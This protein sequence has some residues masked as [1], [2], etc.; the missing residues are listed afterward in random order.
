VFRPNLIQRW[1]GEKNSPSLRLT[2]ARERYNLPCY[3][4]HH[5]LTDALAAAE[6]FLA[7]VQDQF[8]PDT[9]VSD[10]LHQPAANR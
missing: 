8:T 5:A 10:L 7:Q 3:R 6:L 2:H 9:P 4:P 1:M